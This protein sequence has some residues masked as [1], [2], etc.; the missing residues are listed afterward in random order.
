MRNFWEE[1]VVGEKEIKS[2]L[3]TPRFRKPEIAKEKESFNLKELNKLIKNQMK[4]FPHGSLP[5][6]IMLSKSPGFRG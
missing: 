1:L 5:L 6:P 4:D 3:F 2:K